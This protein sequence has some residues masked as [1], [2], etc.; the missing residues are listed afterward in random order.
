[1]I[2]ERKSRSFVNS[3]RHAPTLELVM[4]RIDW[5]VGNRCDVEVGKD[6]RP[7]HL[8]R[9]HF[10]FVYFNLGRLCVGASEKKKQETNEGK[11]KRDDWHS[12]KKE[13]FWATKK[14]SA[15]DIV[16]KEDKKLAGW[17]YSIFSWPSSSHHVKLGTTVDKQT[18]PH[19]LEDHHHGTV[20]V[21][22]S[23]RLRTGQ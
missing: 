2:A 10:S 12:P 20:V 15:A 16:M 11:L 18:V 22:L 13:G 5:L 7:S 23:K 19:G 8:G 17:T 4:M 9:L 1:M 6:C 14:R 3:N 21:L